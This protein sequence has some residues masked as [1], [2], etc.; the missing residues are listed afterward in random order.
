MVVKLWWKNKI[1]LL[2]NDYY[3]NIV[4]RS[5]K[6]KPTSIVKTSYLTR[7]IISS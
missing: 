7:D 4:E 5:C 1:E 3:I 6:E 2:L